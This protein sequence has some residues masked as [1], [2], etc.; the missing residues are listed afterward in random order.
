MTKRA[1]RQRSKSRVPQRA[2]VYI[3]GESPLVEEYAELCASRGYAVLVQWNEAPAVV[4]AFSS[5]S[6]RRTTV[7]PA[8]TSVALE[9]TN[10]NLPAKQSNLKKLDRALPSTALL[11]SSSITV[12]ATEQATWLKFPHRLCGFSALPSFT[13]TGAVEIAPGLSTARGSV[14]VTHRF[15]ESLGKSMEVVQDCVGMVIPRIICQII[16]EATFA[17]QEDIA[18]PNDIDTAMKLGTNYPHG[19]L[20]WGERIGFRT[21]FH[22]LNALHRDL[23]EERYRV[24]PLLKQLALTGEWWKRERPGSDAPGY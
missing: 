2:T 6:I 9:L 21:V 24:S 19:P 11:L 4:P 1:Q 13:H 3:V 10:T 5:V 20:E 17:V 7:I 22:V 16:N 15:L 14:E 18:S 8:T 12:T 23:G